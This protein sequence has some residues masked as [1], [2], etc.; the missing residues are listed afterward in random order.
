MIRRVSL[1]GVISSRY[2]FEIIALVVLLKEVSG[3]MYAKA[4]AARER[5]KKPFRDDLNGFC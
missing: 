3:V 4:Y 5:N 1:V 2:A